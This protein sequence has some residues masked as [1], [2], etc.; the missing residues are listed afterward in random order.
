M[1]I[2]WADKYRPATLAGYVFTDKDQENEIRHW[3]KGGVLP[4]ILLSGP[5]GTG[6]TTLLRVLLREL[7]IDP[8]D[9]TEVNA[10]KD[11]GVD[12][13]KRLIDVL[14]ERRGNGRWHYIFLDEADGLSAAAQGI[15]RAAIEKWSTSVRFL[16]TC[17]YPNKIT[18]AL[19]SRFSTGRMHID[20]LDTDEF[21][22]RLIN[23]LEAEK[24]VVDVHALEELV[25][26]AYPD[27]RE[28]INTMQ[29]W[30]RTGTLTVPIETGSQLS[31]LQ[32]TVVAL[33]RDKKYVEA[34]Q[35]IAAQ[36]PVGEYESMFRF[37]YE[38]LEWWAAG[39]ITKERKCLIVI[40]EGAHRHTQVADVEINLSATLARLEQIVTGEDGKY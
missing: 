13:I 32:T 9:I 15:L 23:I 6:K 30:S 4:H 25:Q 14:S 29:R 21:C 34:R 8:W 37:M 3:I 40:A 7:K 38:N 39:D 5:P 28:G 35:L 36:M 2:L 33:F 17:N 26:K 20:K 11:S 10:S 16:L 22:L 24:I 12:F 27:L 1:D 31:D 19:W 18:P